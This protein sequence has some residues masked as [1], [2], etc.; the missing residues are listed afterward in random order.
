MDPQ[1][2]GMLQG[3]SGWGQEEEG[4]YAESLMKQSGAQLMAQMGDPSAQTSQQMGSRGMGRVA[5]LAQ[6]SEATYLHELIGSQI[7]ARETARAA[8]SEV[9]TEMRELIDLNLKQ[10]AQIHEWDD[11]ER[12]HMA[13]QYNEYMT[14]IE[15][16]LGE[17]SGAGALDTE[18]E[19]NVVGKR[20]K[21]ANKAFAEATTDEERKQVTIYYWG[22]M[23]Y[24]PAA[25][26]V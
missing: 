17:L 8:S 11:D 22:E 14:A 6:Q 7:A 10:Q 24:V 25:T 1:V 20:L 12:T 26:N 2:A 15:N 4:E 5:Q 19:W 9:R 21:E 23:A 13:N 3:I 16:I 18:A